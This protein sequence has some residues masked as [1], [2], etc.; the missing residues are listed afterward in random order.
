MPKNPLDIAREA[1][2]QALATEKRNKQLLESIGPAII[3]ALRPLFVQ[4]ENAISKLKVDVKPNVYVSP[5]IKIPAI[6]VPPI[7]YRPP[8]VIVNY[9][10]PKIEI[11]KLDLPAF[12]IPD[13]KWPTNPM[14]IMGSV[15]LADIDLNHPLPVQIRDAKGNPVSLGGQQ[16]AMVMGNGGGGPNAYIMNDLLHPVPVTI[17]SGAGSSTAAVLTNNDG[18]TYNSDNP[19]PVTITSGAAATSAANIVDSGGVPYT[20]SNPF[21]VSIVSGGTATSSTG[22]ND[23]AGTPYDGSNPVPVAIISDEITL[24][25]T[26]DSI[27]QRQVSGFTDSVNVTLF[28]GNTPAQGNN[29][30]NGGVLRTILMSDSVFS[31]YVN[32]PVD[33]GDSAVALRTV[34]AGNSVSSVSIASIAGP[35]AQG[36][37]AAALRVVQAGDAG[38]SVQGMVQGQNETNAQVLR[39]VHMTDTA[40]SANVVSF[41]GNIPSQGQNETNAG[42]LRVVHMTDTAVSVNIVNTNTLDIHQ[43]S[44]YIDSVNVLQINGNTPATGQNET[45]AGVLR[46]VHMTDTAVSVNV[47][48]TN[49][50]DIHQVSGYT[51]SVNVIAFNSN[52]PAQGLNETNAGVLRVVLMSDSV[53][54]VYAQ[55]PVGNGDSAVALRVTLA[56]NAGASA[57]ITDFA[58][59]IPAQGQNETVGGV[60]RVVQMT[61]TV[62]STQAKLI[63]RQTNPTATGDTNPLFQSADKLGRAL[64]RPIQVRELIAT[65]YGTAS[66]QAETTL[67]TA[68]AAT[69]LDLISIMCAN[70]SNAAV[71]VDIRATV[72]GNIV[73]SIEVPANG[74]AG[75][76]P[77]VPWPQDSTGNGWSFKNPASDP[78]NTTIIVSALF[79]KEV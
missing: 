36:D 33:N 34:Q 61:D 49:T 59:N 7:Q 43:V 64:N 56:G 29:E 42:T 15:R 46:V 37:S 39:I 72:G 5:E 12:K 73:Q 28:N 70:T 45:N 52:T 31:V 74:T 23:R 10:P 25:Q 69:F 51:D 54:S 65:A 27:A 76:V 50:L 44:G 30:T 75:W 13:L 79:T 40:L 58:G 20:G 63:A 17:T 8:E 77:P 60:L 78:S 3:S 24:D 14:P 1:L 6:T 19:L 41:A 66:T 68:G 48:N 26:T 16:A 71:Q 4:L 35:I 2:D 55:N 67:L 47:V 57:S 11:P 18:T 21:P 53:Y 32:N 62:T 9:T 38:V 22:L